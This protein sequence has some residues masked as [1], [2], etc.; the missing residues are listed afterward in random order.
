MKERRVTDLARWPRYDKEDGSM[1]SLRAGGMSTAIDDE[2]Y[3][4]EHHCT[5]W[6][7]SCRSPFV[8]ALIGSAS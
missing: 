3:V 6:T 4:A 8:G 5:F 2:A 1:L 7:R